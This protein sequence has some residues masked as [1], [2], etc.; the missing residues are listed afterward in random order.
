MER[1]KEGSS[2][3]TLQQWSPASEQLAGCFGPPVSVSDANDSK[4]E[5]KITGNDRQHQNE[6][7]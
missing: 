3:H 4:A 1:H 2:R 5:T 6:I 7:M